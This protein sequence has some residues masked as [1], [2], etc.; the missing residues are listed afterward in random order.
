MLEH[1]A[2]HVVEQHVGEVVGAGGRA[3]GGLQAVRAGDDAPE[4]VPRLLQA[5]L[6]AILE[7]DPETE[8][9]IC[10]EEPENGVHPRRMPAVLELLQETGN[11][12]RTVLEVGVEQHQVRPRRVA[13]RRHQFVPN[14]QIVGEALG[15]ATREGKGGGRS[16]EKDKAST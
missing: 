6:Q 1:A 8:G 3:A 16:V 2:T 12:L 5:P 13:R 15:D 10:L 7:I 9:L 11:L 4:I 14:C